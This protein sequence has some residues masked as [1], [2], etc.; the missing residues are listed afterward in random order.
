M[1]YL[2]PFTVTTAPD[3]RPLTNLGIEGYGSPWNFRRLTEPE[4]TQELHRHANA[5]SSNVSGLRVD[6]VWFQPAK[7]EE[8][9]SQDRIYA[10]PCEVAGEK[11]S[12]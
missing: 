4:L 10:G 5:K 11:W 2:A 1:S 6:S 7:G 8:N 12:L 3:G 9:A